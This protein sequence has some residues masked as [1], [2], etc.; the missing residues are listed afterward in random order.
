MRRLFGLDGGNAVERGA[1]DSAV[2]AAWPRR[3]TSGH[4]ARWSLLAAV[5]VVALTC[6]AA[7]D[8]EQDFSAELPRIPPHEPA[9]ALETFEV[10]PGF[11]I[12]QVAAEPHVT[13][14]VAMSFDERG[15]LYV[16]E[17]VDYSEDDK[18]NLGIVRLLE[19]I[20]GDGRFDH[21]SVF[22]DRLSWPTALCCYDG[23]VFVGAAPDIYYCKDTNGDGKADVQKLVFTGFGRSNVQGLFN[24]FQ[25]G[26][27][28][29]IHGATSSSGGQVT[30]PLRPDDPPVNLNGRDFTI[31]PR[32]MT[33]EP[34]SGGAQHGMTFDDWGRKFVCSNSDHIQ[35]VM[36][37][38]RYLARNPHLSAP[39]PRLSI[40]ADGPQAEV[41]RISPVEP[42][43]IVRTRLR[44]SGAVPGIVEGGGRAAGYFTGATGTTIYRGDAW[45][46]EYRGQAFVGDVGSNIIHRKS[47]EP[48]GVE[49]IAR[50]A[51][52]GVEFVASTDIWFR[53]AQ[54]ANAPDGNL[55]IADVY[56][57]V[58]EHPASLPPVIKRH[59]D[60]TSGRGM[61]RIYR[62]VPDGYEQRQL[63]R[64]DQAST[65]ELVKTLN[66][67]NGWH[68]DTAARLLYQRQDQAAIE[69]LER[70]A[71]NSE[72]PL[73]R[74]HSLYAL[75][76]M[77][78]LTE[79]VLLR[80]LADVSPGVRR[81]AVRL[82]EG[83]AA[84][85]PALRTKL[86]EMADDDDLLVRY[87]LAFTLGQFDGA[88][89]L[90]ALARI[91]RGDAADRWVGLAVL[92]SLNTGGGEVFNDL[93]ADG[94]FRGTP[95]GRAF[96]ERLATMVGSQGR[97]DE[98][99]AVVRGLQSLTSDETE[100][101]F[102]LVRAL[103]EGLAKTGDPL[104]QALADA[105]PG[106]A[107]K[108]LDDLLAEARRAAEDQ[109]AG[110]ERRAEA[111]RTLRLGTYDAAAPLLTPLLDNRQ[112]QDLQLAALTTLDRFNE[113]GVAAAV[114]DAWPGFSPRLR[115]TAVE[116]LFARPERLTA[117]LDAVESGT[118][119][120]AEL[121]AARVA[122]LL[123]H[124][125]PAIK[126]R[127]ESLFA[128]V[129][130]G[131]RQDVVDA[132]QAVL[133]MQG[134]AGRGKLAF[135]KVCAAC[136]KAEDMG[137]EIGPNLATIKNRGPETI[138]L[139]VLDPNREVNPQYV[140]YVLIT[141][142]G[143]SMTG[144]IAAET[145]T[146]VTLKRAENA[147][148]TVLRINIDQLEST[149]LSLMPEGVEKQLDQQAMADLIAYLGTLK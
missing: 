131:R 6:Q 127:A 132:Y 43:R 136:H 56:R 88:E 110:L 82:T 41:F 70:Q 125:D 19:D 148:D 57:E 3:L 142:D 90:A 108:L 119:S 118:V 47:L 141:D 37:E 20:D 31:D 75:D 115:S 102:A 99:A 94:K 104:R 21:S 105:D 138:L 97:Q 83:L 55:Y 44:M 89:R 23:G 109:D 34:E 112:P 13:D 17:M 40:A 81:H 30:T 114:L 51:D 2:N 129:K 48:N 49:L 116:A 25:W 32:T 5:V 15:R 85:S 95:A 69:P 10:H 16:V 22:S 144:M 62:V 77:G 139:N 33:I 74:M 145:A 73:G 46:A 84:D 80:A 66:H 24:S 107:D 98:L 54:Y 9:A 126:G 143:R 117:L 36:F 71:I 111:I 147:S 113:P 100:L 103:G 42:W 60:L 124:A 106:R 121:E 58:I 72:S 8:A 76:G 146:S 68:R 101:S 45:P 91:A 149:R 92:S 59:L 122:L 123:N 27:D 96:L 18:A 14:P 130:L 38:D 87:Q 53:P 7:D 11:H 29:R 4:F 134:D 86:C 140:N 64:L 67:A 26:L 61:G 79:A 35:L 135:K 137:H 78:G 52:E 133:A 128:A 39:G 28:N 1:E 12:Q 93:V 63:P 50:R 65:A 120:P